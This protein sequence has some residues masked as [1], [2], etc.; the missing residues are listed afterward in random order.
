MRKPV[1]VALDLKGIAR[2]I[3]SGPDRGSLY[4]ADRRVGHRSFSARSRWGRGFGSNRVG[5][6]R[7]QLRGTHVSET[8]HIRSSEPSSVR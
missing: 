4:R 6:D 8:R 3:G 5:V 7:G 2:W 1:P